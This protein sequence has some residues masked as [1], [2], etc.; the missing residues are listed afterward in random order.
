MGEAY[1]H[2]L[3]LT[4]QQE[5]HGREM[6]RRQELRNNYLVPINFAHTRNVPPAEAQAALLG[7]TEALHA[8]G[9]ERKIVNLGSQTF[10]QGEYSSPEWYVEE[11]LREQDFK[12]NAGHGLQVSARKLLDLF[13]E[14]PWQKNPHWEIFVINHDLTDLG[15]K[16]LLNFVFGKT[17]IGFAASVQSITRLMA[18][19]PAGELRNS[20]IRRLL[21]HEA[22]HMLKLPHLN[23]TN[24]EKKLGLHCTNI[25]TMRQGMS[26]SE[27]SKLTE[28]ED[29]K[30]IHF[31]A[32]CQK[33][34]DR[35]RN[36]YKP[37]PH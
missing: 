18:E 22:G 12:R 37:L 9:Q 3:L 5:A 14:E 35:V 27:W 21:R 20:M 15:E 25:C 11:A 6:A 33:D 24:T 28:E 17:N 10:G 19:I 8:S 13:Y 36:R 26:I 1:F 4:P 29:S 16:G 34:L 31:C 2:P 30:G 7:V 23:R 32:D